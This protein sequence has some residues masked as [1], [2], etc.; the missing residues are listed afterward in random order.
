M[1]A[2]FWVAVSF[3]LFI[4]FLIYKKIPG[5][6]GKNLDEKIQEIKQKIEDAENLKIESNKLLSK[7]QDQLDQSKKECEEILLRAT[8]VN[9]E[10]SSAMEEKI[11]SMELIFSSIADDSSAF[12]LVALNKISSHSFFDWSS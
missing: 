5:L 9:A 1:D 12:T 10:E 3:F 11:S 6:V 4:A 2:T 7:Y 8:K